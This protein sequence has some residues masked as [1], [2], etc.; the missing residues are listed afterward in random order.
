V[1][2]GHYLEDGGGHHRRGKGGEEG[3]EG[4]E[5]YVGVFLSGGPVEW[6]FGVGR[7]VPEN[8]VGILDI[9]L[10]VEIDDWRG[11]GPGGFEVGGFGLQRLGRD[12]RM[13]FEV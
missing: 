12:W 5:G 4:E 13:F 6:V 8:D 11:T 1:K 9:I 7:A 2:F 3:E 10:R